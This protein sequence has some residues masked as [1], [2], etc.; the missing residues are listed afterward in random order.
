MKP[1]NQA[2]LTIFELLVSILIGSIVL[3][4]LTSVLS[5]SMKA[6][7]DLD[8]TNRM[9]TETYII[10]EQIQQNI[11]NLQPQ[12]LEIVEGTNVT[13]VYIRH[14]F[15]YVINPTTGVIEPDYSTAQEDVLEFVYDDITGK[16][17]L[18]YNGVKLHGDNVYFTQDTILS[19]ES[20]NPSSCDL[21]VSECPEGIIKLSLS[22]GLQLKTGSIT[23]KTYV[24]TILV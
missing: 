6:K 12:S 1:L 8:V 10:G 20:I 13:T 3:A 9:Q 11:F 5:M 22:V 15:D 14:N 2:G 4:M 23:S 7:A 17:E 19:L 18:T 24:I 21:S 16:G